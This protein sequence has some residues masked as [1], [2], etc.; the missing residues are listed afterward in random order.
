MN[1]LD[2]G[3]SFLK[4][5]RFL[6]FA[7]A[8]GLT[9]V[10][11]LNTVLISA[12][13]PPSEPKQDRGLGLQ[14]EPAKTSN[15]SQSKPTSAAPEL[16]LQTGYTA[17]SM[18]QTLTFS[19][20]GLLLATT[21]F[22]SNQVKIWEVTTGHELRTFAISGGASGFGPATLSGVSAVAFSRDGSLLAAGGRDNSITVWDLASGRELL[23]L[24]APTGTITSGL[25]IMM[26]AFSA[27]GRQLVSVGDAFRTWDVGTGQK[28]R[29]TEFALQSIGGFGF[30]NLALS[31]DGTQF[32]LFLNSSTVNEKPAV[33]VYE[34]TT[35]A[36]VRS[37]NI[38]EDL[39]E[40][41]AAVLS[42]TPE[43]HVLAAAIDNANAGANAS[44][45]LKFLDLTAG[46]K[47]RVLT[48]VDGANGLKPLSFSSD[49][50][51][52]AMGSGQTARLWDLKSNT[53]RPVLKVAS[54]SQF[55]ERDS[56]TGL[57]FSPDG[58]TLATGAVNSPITLW[59]TETGHESASLSGHTNYAANVAFSPDGTRLTSGTRTIW[60]VA[61]GRGLRASSIDEGFGT[62]SRDGRL[63][64]ST[65]LKDNKVTLY[66]TVKQQELFTLTPA[67]RG[68]VARLPVFSPDGRLL[69]TAYRQT[70]EDRQAAQNA[71]FNPSAMQQLSKDAMKKMS[72]DMLKQMQ[73]NPQAAMQVY[74]DMFMKQAAP[75]TGIGGKV[76]LWDTATGKEVATLKVPASSPF[77]P[78]DVKD[79]SFT[80]DGRYIAVTT[81][82]AGEVTFWNVATGALVRTFSSQPAAAN[83][84]ASPFTLP[85]G[86][87]TPLGGGSSITALTFSADG[88]VLATGGKESKSNFDLSTYMA[89]AAKGRGKGG[90]GP[91]P[92]V[93]AQ[94]AMK[95]VQVS[96]SGPIKLWDVSTGRELRTLTGHT[97]EV[98]CLALSPDGARLASAAADNNIKIWD[99]ASGREVHTLKGHSA[100]INSLAFS[101]DG[102]LL[103][104]AADDGSTRLWDAATGTHLAT[105]I[106]LYDGAEWLVVTPDGLFD[107]SP[108]AWNQILWRYDQNTFSVAPVESYFKDFFSPGLLSDLAAGK[109]PVA[110]RKIEQL[111]RRL[112][113]LKLTLA[114]PSPGDA[115]LTARNQRVRIEI[116]EAPAGARDVRLFRNG[117]LVKVWHGDAQAG[118]VVETTVPIVAGANQFAAY[119]FNRDNVKST[120]ARL[121]VNGDA[122]LKRAGV[123]YVLAI[124]VNTY[125]NSEY[126]LKYAVADAQDFGAEVQR[127]VAKLGSFAGI[128]V[129]PL[130]DK[131]STKAN[132]LAAINVLG[133]QVGTL[134]HGAPAAL[135]QLKRTEPEDA[136]LIFFAGHGTA[137]QQRFYL[138]PHD[139]GYAGARSGLD[140]AGL[141]EVLSHS[142]SDQELELALESVDA[143]QLLLV[144]DACNSGQA[145]EAEEKRRGPMN[146]KGLAQLAYEKG[147]YI[148]TAAQS[149]QAAQEV[150]QVGHGLLTY[151]LV[152]EGLKQLAADVE[153]RDKRILAREWLDYAT[154][155]VPEMQIEKLAQAAGAGRSLSFTD[156]DT[157]PDARRKFQQRPRVFYRRELEAQPLIIARP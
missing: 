41:G 88:R 78:A 18:V 45:T 61:S 141:R 33:K 109:R 27:D 77:I 123:L 142:I 124:G 79:I 92:A 21:A 44:A 67:E 38:P 47:A 25:G 112:P 96:S 147:M 87:Q 115:P 2:R 36:E 66:D 43:G 90:K 91:D 152:E 117:S 15:D 156:D 89:Q 155:R 136:V 145:L 113:K 120:D 39:N 23:T 84:G 49:G 125:A 102:H 4:S 55:G 19:P 20:N 17:T 132:I 71:A 12:Q 121:D 100:Q 119:A 46:G 107:G 151:A 105:L 111:D 75:A 65:L 126:N 24:T 80:A 6:R 37:I 14:P 93:L 108:G 154:D 40:N 60:E 54:G 42:F 140:D 31:R 16:V 81:S 30:N 28:V 35:G 110:P 128:E 3:I 144:I 34:L 133:G 48:N 22:S 5:F 149:F 8:F 98:K 62:L 157:S 114:D 83:T 74:Q 122:K 94:E 52:L 97:T 26:L 150:A 58:K 130:L 57:S 143:A 137:Q 116:A 51:W 103:A 64:A 53:E 118:Q 10:L 68:L 153:P 76:K 131:D 9:A 134:S 70:E 1:A 29:E 32:A 72:K 11:L 59:E 135:A 95:K 104:S 86:L 127:Q 56:V 13:T 106:S 99:V 129:V 138:I 73:K 82:Y 146:S 148:L 7:Y 85:A 101:P 63:M 50:R 139:L 69:A